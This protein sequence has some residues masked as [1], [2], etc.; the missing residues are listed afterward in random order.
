MLLLLLA[1]CGGGLTGHW[2]GNIACGDEDAQGVLSFD[3]DL[4]KEDDDSY[5][6]TGLIGFSGV[7]EISGAMRDYVSTQ[8]LDPVELSLEAPS[9]AQQVEMTGTV[10]ECHTTIDGE[11]SDQGC[12][13]DS[14]TYAF[15]WDGADTLAFA[16]GDCAGDLSRD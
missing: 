6:G 1:A 16:E 9:G 5:V 10:V 12:G 2:T 4:E 3:L 8:T 15:D 11:E 14:V 7:F 13:N